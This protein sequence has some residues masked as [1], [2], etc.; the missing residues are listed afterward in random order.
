MELK[1]KMEQE[2]ED[3][4]PLESGIAGADPTASM[5]QPEEP[6]EKRG[7]KPGS[8]NRHSKAAIRR[9][10]QCG[11][12]PIVKMVKLYEQ[13]EKEIDAL[14]KLRSTGTAVIK[15]DGT[16]AK[17]SFMAHAQLLTL[18]QKLVG[19][20]LRYAYAR[21]PETLQIDAP[22]PTGIVI[23]L[24]GTP[25]QDIKDITPEEED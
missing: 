23:N 25:K 14:V 6:P 12:D 22:P 1:S 16:T 9:L 20:L 3:L 2:L 10:A 7:R 8:I 15:A 11:F 13:V 24:S 17:Y 18:Q 5:V 4:I 19:D 21:V